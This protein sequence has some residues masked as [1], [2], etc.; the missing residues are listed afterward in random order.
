[1]GTIGGAALAMAAATGLFYLLAV[2]ARRELA[3][4]WRGRMIKQIENRGGRPPRGRRW[5]F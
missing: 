3:H 4:D 5:D 1:M 2:M